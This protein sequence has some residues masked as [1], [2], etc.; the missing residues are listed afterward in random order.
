MSWSNSNKIK[1]IDRKWK[2]SS[3]YDKLSI[4]SFKTKLIK[5]A[6]KMPPKYFKLQE[7]GQMR[8][9]NNRII[10][11]LASNSQWSG[12]SE[13][14]TLRV[15][16]SRSTFKIWH[17]MRTSCVL[18]ASF[19]RRK[20]EAMRSRL[21]HRQYHMNLEHRWE[22]RWCFLSKYLAASLWKTRALSRC[23]L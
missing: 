22:P 12:Q 5:T 11:L 19:L 10:S 17:S 18:K 2:I 4:F 1:M 20:I 13:S 23:S 15:Q 21:I 7:K 14:T 3:R 9:V 8:M 16:L 6:M